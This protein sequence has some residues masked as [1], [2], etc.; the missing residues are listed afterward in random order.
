[1]SMPK[2]WKCIS[3]KATVE[4]SSKS[5]FGKF[6]DTL[7]TTQASPFAFHT[8]S[9]KEPWLI[10]DLKKSAPICGLLIQNR[11]DVQ[12]K[13][14][15]NLHVWVSS[16]KTN[17]KKVYETKGAKKE[18]LVKV[19]PAQSARYVKIGMLNGDKPEFFHLKG[20]RIFTPE[21]K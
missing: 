21:A 14:I 16:D 12:F 19:D 13:R 7:L 15:T 9:E 3:E 6:P 18:W 8:E 10:I 17:W 5:K 20:V 4:Y 1:M 2:G 11:D